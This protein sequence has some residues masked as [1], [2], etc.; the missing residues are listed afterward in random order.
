MLCVWW[1]AKER[2]WEEFSGTGREEGEKKRE[3]K[4]NR[5]WGR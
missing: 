3:I 1:P 4:N 5:V 2:A